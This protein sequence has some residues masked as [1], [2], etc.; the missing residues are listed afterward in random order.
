WSWRSRDPM[1]GTPWRRLPSSWPLPPRM[2][3]L[4]ARCRRRD[5][6]FNQGDG[7]SASRARSHMEIKRGI[8]VSPGVAIGPAMVLDTE[9]FRIPQRFVEGTH[10]QEEVD[11]VRKALAAAAREAH[12]HDRLVAEKL[13]PQSGAI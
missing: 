6:Q 1:R 7:L 9:W 11:R 13:G 2:R 10:A 3:T 4:S 5:R 12:G 8:P